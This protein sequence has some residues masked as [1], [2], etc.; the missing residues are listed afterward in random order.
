[1]RHDRPPMLPSC[2]R[3]TSKSGKLPLPT[4][5]TADPEAVRMYGLYSPEAMSVGL[6]TSSD[7]LVGSHLL[8]RRGG[9][10]SPRKATRRTQIARVLC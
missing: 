4:R 1:M 3:V 8:A 7:T 5:L 9:I 2:D 6:F 10:S